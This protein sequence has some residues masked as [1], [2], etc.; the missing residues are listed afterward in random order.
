MLTLSGVLQNIFQAPEATNKDGIKYGGESR[1]QIMA[2]NMLQ[3][4]Q[5]KIELVNL[6]VPSIQPF[7]E[8][9]GETVQIPVGVFVKN[10]APVFYVIKGAAPKV[11]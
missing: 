9:V 4:G 11:I 8:L 1:I 10:N 7:K 5:K 6:T 3:N 2:E